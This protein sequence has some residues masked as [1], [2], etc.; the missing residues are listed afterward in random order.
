MCVWTLCCK[1]PDNILAVRLFSILLRICC[2][3]F[4]H[5]L[6]QSYCNAALSEMIRYQPNSARFL[7]WLLHTFPCGNLIIDLIPCTQQATLLSWCYKYEYPVRTS[8]CIPRSRLCVSHF[9]LPVLVT[10]SLLW[11]SAPPWMVSPAFCITVCGTPFAFVRSIYM[12]LLCFVFSCVLL[13][14][15]A[16]CPS[17]FGLICMFWTDTLALTLTCLGCIHFMN[18]WTEPALPAASAFGPKSFLRVSSFFYFLFIQTLWQVE[19]L[20]C[21]YFLEWANYKIWSQF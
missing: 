13:L 4:H 14:S 20:H 21:I 7:T 8:C 9:A 3:T 1:T 12:L 6:T 10:F 17:P 11:L 5:H 2:I 15:F 19:D 16:F 18:F